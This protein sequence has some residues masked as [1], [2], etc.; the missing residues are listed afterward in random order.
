MLIT[1]CFEL[2]QRT[3]AAF[4]VVSCRSPRFI[5]SRSL[6]QQD[7]GRNLDF[8]GPSHFTH[9]KWD[10]LRESLLQVFEVRDSVVYMITNEAGFSRSQRRHLT[11]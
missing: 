8:C 6:T 2:A 7:V 10:S 1:T 3:K 4:F 5:W 9:R 11:D